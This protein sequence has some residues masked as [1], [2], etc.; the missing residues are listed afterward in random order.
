[1]HRNVL[2][3]LGLAI[4]FQLSAQGGAA[5]TEKVRF[6]VKTSTKTPQQVAEMLPSIS[7]M[8]CK[9]FASVAFGA[10]EVAAGLEC[11]DRKDIFVALGEI[12]AKLDGIEGITMAGVEGK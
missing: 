11:N 8:N 3:A 6:F 7:L 4:V 5:A 2:S 9:A 10:D 12:A 1:M